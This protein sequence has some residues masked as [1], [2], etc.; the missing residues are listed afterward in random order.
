MKINIGFIENISIKHELTKIAKM[1]PL[2]FDSEKSKWIYHVFHPKIVAS[3]IGITGVMLVIN[4]IFKLMYKNSP[5][6][7]EIFKLGN[8]H[9]LTAEIIPVMI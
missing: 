6:I 4:R 9:Y 5:S 7:D 8:K 2:S 3:D 1:Y